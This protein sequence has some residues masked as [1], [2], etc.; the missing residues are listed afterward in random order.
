MKNRME[1]LSELAV[2]ANKKRHRFVGGASKGDEMV[3]DHAFC[4]DRTTMR[5]FRQSA[6]LPQQQ[7]DSLSYRFHSVLQEHQVSS[8]KSLTFW[9][10]CI[11]NSRFC[12]GIKYG[13]AVA[14]LV[15]FLSLSPIFGLNPARAATSS[16]QPDTSTGIFMLFEP[17]SGTPDWLFVQNKKGAPVISNPKASFISPSSLQVTWTTDIPSSSLVEYGSPAEYN[18]DRYPFPHD[19]EDQTDVTS[20]ALTINNVSQNSG[21]Y[22]E[23]RSN[24]GG[25]LEAVSPVQTIGNISNMPNGSPLPSVSNLPEQQSPTT[26]KTGLPK[27]FDSILSG[28]QYVYSNIINTFYSAVGIDN[29][30]QQMEPVSNS[31]NQTPV[32]TPNVSNTI[33]PSNSIL[34]T[35]TAS[36]SHSQQ[37]IRTATPAG[38]YSPSPTQTSTPMPIYSQSPVP[39]YSPTPTYIQSLTPIYSPAPSI[40]NSPVPTNPYSPSPT[41]SNNPAPTNSN[42]PAPTNTPSPAVTFTVNGSDHAVL[43]PGDNI[44][45]KWNATDADTFTATYTSNNP[46]AC[47]PGGTWSVANGSQSGISSSIV[48]QAAAAC[49]W[50]V[51]Y[52]ATNSRT[53]I[54][55]SAAI[56]VKIN[57]PA[58]ASPSPTNS[59]TP[60]AS[61][62]PQAFSTDQNWFTA[63]AA[64]VINELN[65]IAPKPIW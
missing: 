25:A 7:E 55:A 62:S 35:I 13:S 8:Y 40:S 64:N 42:T 41:A 4:G 34:P 50:T 51:T 37:P 58:T 36:P 63:A 1:K 56:T 47:G 5:L 10:N 54:F 45:Y 3:N 22:Y 44:I 14:V 53:G 33:E 26:P 27:F 61:P 30:P 23:V 24:I 65:F 6:G 48:P 18:S 52:K 43:N 17:D 60:T 31:G 19:A 32:I 12:Q 28:T 39:T 46:V 21:Y 15:A 16:S 20:H 49:Y 9:I 2:T 38:T 11:P 57:A 29:Q 59:A